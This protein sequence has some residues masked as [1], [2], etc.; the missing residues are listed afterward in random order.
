MQSNEGTNMRPVHAM[1]DEELMCHLEQLHPGDI[2]LKFQAAPGEPQRRLA[3]PELWRTY[4]DTLH[5]LYPNN[6]EHTHE[7]DM[8]KLDHNVRWVD[9]PEDIWVMV[10]VGD[11]NNVADAFVAEEAARKAE[12]R[13]DYSWGVEA[14]KVKL[15]RPSLQPIYG[16]STLLEALWNEM[17][18]LM[19]QLMQPAGADD[20]N[21]RW[22]AEELAWVI[23]IVSNP[24]EP[25]MD[26][27]RAEAMERWNKAQEDAA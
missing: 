3:A 19:Q 11:G 21:D 24:Y 2:R 14:V 12:E 17:D 18:R 7:A 1:D 9:K 16:G 27:V 23:A 6:Y 22:R 4:H 15:H 20:P 25:S 26:R 13:G 8:E 5:R 10:R